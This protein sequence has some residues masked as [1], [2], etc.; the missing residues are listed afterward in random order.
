[1]IRRSWM[2]GAA[3]A[4]VLCAWTTTGLADDDTIRL[5]LKKGK[6]A[7]TMNLLGADADTVEARWYGGWRG[8]YRGWYGGYRGWY[9]GYRGWYGGFYRP[10]YYRPW[11][12]FGLGLGYPYYAG[13][14]SPYYYSPYV[15]APPVYYT[16]SVYYV[17]AYSYPISLTLSVMRNALLGPDQPAMPY[18]T[19]PEETIPAPQP[20]PKGGTYQYDGGP[21][22]PVP[23]PKPEPAPT[24]KAS[25]TLPSDARL[26]S[27]PAKTPKYSYAAY[28][29]LPAPRKVSEERQL[30]AKPTR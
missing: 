14:Y 13:Y 16:P 1:M 2:L 9:G 12:S 22:N 24:R 20:A 29:E 27:I 7:A 25:P 28:G 11:V 21:A 26:V 17:P 10:Y 23:M 4:A 15:Y 6:E 5:D 18:A 3:A 30:A 19:S 8:G